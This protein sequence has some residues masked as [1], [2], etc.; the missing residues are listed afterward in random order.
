M[1]EN[2]QLIVYQEDFQ[3]ATNN[4]NTF[5]DGIVSC[6]RIGTSDNYSDFTQSFGDSGI[7]FSLGENN[8]GVLDDSNPNFS[9]DFRDEAG[10]SSCAEVS[11]LSLLDALVAITQFQKLSTNTTTID[12]IQAKD[13]LDTTIFEL[14]G[15]QTTRQERID[16]FFT[17]YSLLKATPPDLTTDEDQDGQ[18]DIDLEQYDS[19]N[20]I[21]NNN[22]GFIVRLD[23]NAGEVNQDQTLEWLRN[24]L[25]SYFTDTIAG[26]ED[27]LPLYQERSSGYLKFREMNQSVII[28]NTE[29]QQVIPDTWE[30]TG[31]TITMWVKFKD[32]ISSG[33]LFNYGNPLRENQPFGFF[34]ETYVLNGDDNNRDGGA[35]IADVP[36][37]NLETEEV[38]ESQLEPLYTNWKELAEFNNLD[39]FDN[40]EQARFL[41][42]V[43]NANI[44]ELGNPS[45]TPNLYDSH[46]GIP[47]T[48]KA[49]NTNTGKTFIAGEKP[50][51][52]GR[53]RRFITTTNVPIDFNEWYFIV[54]TY[55][56]NNNET[57]DT[58]NK[59]LPL[60]WTGNLL[61]N[62]DGSTTQ[63]HNS[64]LGNKCKVEIISKTDLLRARGFRQ[65]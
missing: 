18:P 60:Y 2:E 21:T 61:I 56:P 7:V 24:D 16:K 22:N 28:R 64:G 58:T 26:E 25:N 29:N 35:S 12:P 3:V 50:N 15:Q 37:D 4:F 47:K 54:A 36:Q 19:Q 11:P 23:K 53:S 32:K 45:D 41:R 38:D 6:F 55:N 49:G 43:V 57:I 31:F 17:E 1:N 63:T 42:L 10:E 30:T 65:E 9:V 14:I 44:D 34:L 39:Y 33:T 8:T 59:N 27:Q 13:V 40:N 46:I 51:S 20:D 48:G 62:Q 5:I 52:T